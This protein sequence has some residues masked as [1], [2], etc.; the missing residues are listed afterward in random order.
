MLLRHSLGQEE[1]ARAVE[2][3][4][5]AVIEAGIVT[6]DLAQPGQRSYSTVAVGDAVAERV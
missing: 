5:S 4:V 2:A 3:A 1:P 6:G